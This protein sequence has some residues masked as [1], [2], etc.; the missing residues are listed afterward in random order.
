MNFTNTGALSSF[1]ASKF[2]TIGVDTNQFDPKQGP[3]LGWLDSKTVNFRLN[4]ACSIDKESLK[5]KT[6]QE[7]KKSSLKQL[8]KKKNHIKK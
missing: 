8:L 2:V 3:D 5:K 1:Q 7:K 4:L 6:L